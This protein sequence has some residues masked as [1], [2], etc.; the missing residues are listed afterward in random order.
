M[1]EKFSFEDLQVYQ[2]SLLFID[3]VYSKTKLFPKEEIYNLTS[4]LRRASTS[5]AL[6]IG[7]GAGGT[8]LEFVNFLRIARRSVNECIVCITIARTHK[9]VDAQSEKEL[10]KHLADISK[11][12]SGL[13]KSLKN[14]EQEVQHQNTKYKIPN[15][16][17]ESVESGDA[18]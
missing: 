4:Q 9:Y 13:V 5:I 8:T 17:N 1:E 15:T 14:K 11:M 12:L 10:R 16:R 3:L 7:E 18:L 2:K 6:N